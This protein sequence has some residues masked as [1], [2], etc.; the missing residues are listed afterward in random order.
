[1]DSPKESGANDS[2]R[3]WQAQIEPTLGD[4]AT[5]LDLHLAAVTEA[6]A[7]GAQI[8]LFPELSLTGYFLKDQTSDVARPLDGPE[9]G[10]LCE[11]TTE[12]SIAFGFVE[13]SPDGRLYNSIAF[14]EDGEILHVHR[15]VHLAT[16][17]MFEE[18]RDFAAGEEFAVFDSKHGRFGI[19]TCEDAWHVGGAWLQ[20][21]AG[22]DALLVH[23]SSPARGVSPRDNG[24][25]GGFASNHTW[26]TILTA[27]AL[28]FRTPVLFTNRVG[29]EDGITFSG[30]TLSIAPDGVRLGRIEGLDPAHLDTTVT[31]DSVRRAR[32]ATPLRRDEKPWTLFK[33]LARMEGLVVEE[34]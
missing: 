30:G 26:E 23:S 4:L 25:E 6:T 1:M 22:A 5:N 13:A 3:F 18:S 34:E 17:G 24:E 32:R 28:F 14:C 10:R 20:Y 8:V 2:V 12:V 27:H 19:L 9:I 21:M 29:V 16:Y 33:G 31:A 15:K 7:A 11:A